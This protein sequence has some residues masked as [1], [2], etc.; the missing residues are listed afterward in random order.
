[1]HQRQPFGPRQFQSD[2]LLV[3]HG[4]HHGHGLL[5]QFAERD[6][7]AAQ[8]AFSRSRRGVASNKSRIMACN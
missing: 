1:M 4:P 8:S 6:A 2:L 7:S 3:G 5:N